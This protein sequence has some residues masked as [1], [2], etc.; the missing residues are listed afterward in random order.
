MLSWLPRYLQYLSSLKVAKNQI[1]GIMGENWHNVGA[2]NEPV[3][4]TPWRS[5]SAGASAYGWVRFFKDYLGFVHLEGI[6]ET[7]G[8]PTGPTLFSLP[9]GY[10]PS[11]ALIFTARATTVVGQPVDSVRIDILGTGEVQVI[12]PDNS[13]F[14]SGSAL[15]LA[16]IHF[17]A[18]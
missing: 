16:G 8:T 18:M 15:S 1:P 5:Y 13:K 17:R 14:T 4:V 11:Q 12:A 6:A 2:Q 3:F 9:A 10:R 7:T